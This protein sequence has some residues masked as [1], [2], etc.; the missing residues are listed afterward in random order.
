MAR[1][2]KIAR[3][4]NYLLISVFLLLTPVLSY[5]PVRAV[6]ALGTG[7]ENNSE[8]GVKNLAN[9]IPDRLQFF[10][11]NCTSFVAYIMRTKGVTYHGNAFMN[12]WDN[13]AH[14]GRWG[15]ATDW[16]AYA[17]KLGYVV[18]RTPAI[19]AV[20]QW[21]AGDTMPWGAAGVKFG[22]AGHVA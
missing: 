12:D 14:L 1:F 19:G 4:I 18:D 2:R 17:P 15:N 6:S 3:F 11:R 13:T 22:S 10:S 7:Y 21:N 16:D 9:N 5:M 20:A 8:Y